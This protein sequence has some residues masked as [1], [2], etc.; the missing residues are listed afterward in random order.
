MSSS[1]V[2]ELVVEDVEELND[3]DEVVEISVSFNSSTYISSV[4]G[5]ASLCFAPP[6]ILIYVSV[7]SPKPF[8]NVIISVV[9]PQYILF[10]LAYST[11]LS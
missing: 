7:S 3:E 6:S 10:L 5:Y 9:P 1:S 4:C 2:K 8:S 11:S